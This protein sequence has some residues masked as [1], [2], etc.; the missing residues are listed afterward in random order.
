MFYVTMVFLRFDR[1]IL[2]FL[3]LFSFDYYM[4]TLTLLLLLSSCTFT[5]FIEV[6]VQLLSPHPYE[7]FVEVPYFLEY[8]N[9]ENY[10]KI[11]LQPGEKSIKVKIQ[12]KGTQVFVASPFNFVGPI[13]GS[14][15]TP[16][17]K[18]VVLT[19]I[20]GQL[21]SALLQASKY[22]KES[23]ESLNY[24]YIKRDLPPSFNNIKFMKEVSDGTFKNFV[25]LKEK[26]FYISKLPSGW[27]YSANSNL[28]NL[29]FEVDSDIYY[30]LII[31]PGLYSFY[32]PERKLEFI[33][34]LTNDG[35][36][37]QQIK[38]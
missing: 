34:E 6:E 18:R 29:Y 27:W 25:P 1:K 38:N 3:Q 30:T 26:K 22:N 24:E 31:F 2:R 13:M 17:D 19:E 35:K 11:F 16:G 5:P 20:E 14:C 33:I 15:Y 36:I 4:V 21:A 10:K 8:S 28:Q 23:V 9:G 32:N 7:K 12:P 37:Q